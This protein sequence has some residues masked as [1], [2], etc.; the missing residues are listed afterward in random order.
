MS[1]D[2][3]P[4]IFSCQM[5][6]IVYLLLGQSLGP[7]TLLSIHIHKNLLTKIIESVLT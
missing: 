3:D 1:A 2:K 5:K 4:S 6:A 7:R